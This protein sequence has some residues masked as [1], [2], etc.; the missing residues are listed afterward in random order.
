MLDSLY[1]A[2][3]DVDTKNVIVIITF[4][5][6]LPSCL[7]EETA[8]GTFGLRVKLSLIFLTQWMLPVV[9]Y[10]KNLKKRQARKL[11]IPIFIVLGLT[12]PGIEPETN[13][14][15]SSIN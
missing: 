4:T 11:Q 10:K 2:Y 6:D 7:G 9:L 1:R 3:G 5:V 15:S 14:F 8:K 12:Q 13:S